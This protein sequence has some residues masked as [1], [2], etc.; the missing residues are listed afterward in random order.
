[1][2]ASWK[3]RF[4]ELNYTSYSVEGIAGELEMSLA[5]SAQN[6][7]AKVQRRPTEL[8]ERHT[9]PID[10]WVPRNSFVGDVVV[11]LFPADK[12]DAISPEYNASTGEKLFLKGP[13]ATRP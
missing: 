8:I 13:S 3:C 10:F 11:Y 6:I 1:M 9:R 2:K 12:N 5:K 7:A 4:N